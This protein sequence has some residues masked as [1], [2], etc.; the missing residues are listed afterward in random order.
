MYSLR[1]FD[2]LSNRKQ[3]CNFVAINLELFDSTFALL[4]QKQEGTKASTSEVILGNTQ[5]LY[6]YTFLNVSS[7]LDEHSVVDCT[8]F[9]TKL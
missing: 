4:C 1:S 2:E 8:F 3:T 6:I 5:I 7:C 9:K